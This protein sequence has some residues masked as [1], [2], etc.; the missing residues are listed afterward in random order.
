MSLKEKLFGRKYH[1]KVE[2]TNRNDAHVIAQTIN[3]RQYSG[4]DEFFDG[5]IQ[6]ALENVSS[7]ALRA[8]GDTVTLT[9]NATSGGMILPIKQSLLGTK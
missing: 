2:A 7:Q 4:G 8:G 1:V 5:M 9:T 3:R 6:R